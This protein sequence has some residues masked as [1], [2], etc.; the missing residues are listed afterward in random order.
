MLKKI[1]CFTISITLLIS[2]TYP[3]LAQELTPPAAEK[4]QISLD[5]KGMDLVDVLKML[6]SRSG[7]NIVVGKNVSGR[8]T[9]FLK[10][11]NIWDAFIIILLSEPS[12]SSVAI[13]N[14]LFHIARNAQVGF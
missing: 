6:A 9:L 10:D 8:V 5:I 13:L 11:V 2:F 3:G 12:V 14:P 7:L 4:G 1:L